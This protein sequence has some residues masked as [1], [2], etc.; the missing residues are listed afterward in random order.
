MLGKTEV[1]GSETPVE[2]DYWVE[3]IEWAE[4]MGAD[5]VSSSLGYDGWYTWE[6]MDGETAVTT[7]AADLAVDKGVLVFNCA[8]NEYN[9]NDH[10][11]LIAPADGKKVL[12]IA[13]VDKNRNRAL[14]S[15][16]GP[17]ADGRIKPDLAAMGSSVIVADYNSSTAFR[18]KSVLSIV[19]NYKF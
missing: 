2:E 9:N 18:Y 6:D 5:I 8:G 1:D 17:S 7:I 14:S 16:V 3:G 15:S 4:S 19:L 12:A 13:S 11:T 10:N